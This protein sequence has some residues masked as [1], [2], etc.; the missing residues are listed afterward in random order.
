MLAAGVD[1]PALAK[2]ENISTCGL[3]LS[4]C[5]STG[6]FQK[7][8][9]L[10]RISELRS[11]WDE[12]RLEDLSDQLSRLVSPFEEVGDFEI[13]LTLPGKDAKPTRVVAPEFIAHPPYC[14]QGRVDKTGRLEARYDYSGTKKRRTAIRRSIW[15]EVDT[16]RV[17]DALQR[18]PACGPFS[19]EIRAWDMDPQSV[20]N[21][22]A[23]FKIAK[24]A[25]RA[26]IRSYKGI[27]VY[28][29]RI[30]VLPKS[31]SS[32]DWLGLDLR[33]VSRVGGRLS[34]SQL[35]GYAAITSEDNP[36]IQDT[37]DRERLVENNAS[38]DFTAL[39]KQVMG[40]MEFEREKDRQEACIVSLPYKTFLP[41]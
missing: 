20:E 4:A 5:P 6:S 12:E 35:V 36:E 8:G 13:W 15:A 29:D 1:W 14:I 10:V 24:G 38:N 26:S 23:T 30:L 16:D 34:T 39:L 2:A 19:F 40:L 37:S 22:A 41:H 32:K 7:T 21:L 17:G 33:R 3:E 18:K 11:E 9:T 27:S 25:V 28:R 31:D